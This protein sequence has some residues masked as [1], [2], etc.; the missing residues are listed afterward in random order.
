MVMGAQEC[1]KELRE[2]RLFLAIDEC[3]VELNDRMV[4]NRRK[5]EESLRNYVNL[6]RIDE[7]DALE[8]LAGYS[9]E[10]D[11]M[12]EMRELMQKLRSEVRDKL[13]PTGDGGR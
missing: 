11:E 1:K 3:I 12:L 4:E 13:S 8:M 10:Y 2:K 5:A 7:E 6:G 9:I